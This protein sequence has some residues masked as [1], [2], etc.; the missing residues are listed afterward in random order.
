MVVKLKPE[1]ASL[2]SNLLVV[3]IVV[4][5]VLGVLLLGGLV[6]CVYR[7]RK[8]KVSSA[9]QIGGHGAGGH[10]AI[11]PL[12]HGV[13]SSRFL[14]QRP[15]QRM[16]ERPGMHAG[17]RLAA[18]CAASSTLGSDNQDFLEHE[19]AGKEGGGGGAGGFIGKFSA[20]GTIRYRKPKTIAN[21]QHPSARPGGTGRA[22]SK[23]PTAAVAGKV[24]REGM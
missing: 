13:D 18:D 20:V 7:R 9:D 4:A 8:R 22:E 17:G 24:R 21:T 16:L 15:D 1:T 3:N 19:G 11:P 2:T 14:L 12:K 10:G 23:P 6:R 5:C